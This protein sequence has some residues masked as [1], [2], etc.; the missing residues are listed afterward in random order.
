MG[1]WESEGRQAT[2]QEIEQAVVSVYRKLR[3]FAG[4]AK[5]NL[6]PNQISLPG[7]TTQGQFHIVHANMATSGGEIRGSDFSV[8]QDGTITANKNMF[9]VAVT[10]MMVGT[11]DVNDTVVLGI[12][13]GSPTQI[14]TRPGIEVGANYVSRFRF[15]GT[16]LG[17]NRE[18]T[19]ATPYE[20]VGK[21]TTSIDVNGIHAGDKL[22]PVLWTQET[23]A[24]TISIIDLI[25][26][27]QEISI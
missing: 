2:S 18:V 9:A 5:P 17:A 23:D 13:I 15:G 25:F 26:T 4:I 11:W 27:V 20:P 12:G 10:C 3:S 6:T 7:V 1:V 14:P 19:L 24:A 22:F 16:G 8:N 21:S